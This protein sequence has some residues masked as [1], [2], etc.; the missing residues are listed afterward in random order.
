MS[1]KD[2]IKTL[3]S[4]IHIR[5]V[6]LSYLTMAFLENTIVSEEGEDI[7]SLLPSTIPSISALYQILVE[8]RF[9]SLDK[10][11][12]IC[13]DFEFTRRLTELFFYIPSQPGNYLSVKD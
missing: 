6:R 5:D 7:S 13:S 3:L 12:L 10:D 1:K 2:A 9:S 8:Y 4:Y 11:L